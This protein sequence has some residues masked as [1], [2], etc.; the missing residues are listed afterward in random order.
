[1][2]NADAPVA[3]QTELKPNDGLTV[4]E[5]SVTIDAVQH[6]AVV[7]PGR[8]GPPVASAHPHSFGFRSDSQRRPKNDAMQGIA[9]RKVPGRLRVVGA[10]R[11]SLTL[12]G[13]RKTAASAGLASGIKK[14]GPHV[15]TLQGVTCWN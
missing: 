4:S 8:G 14:E 5:I 10:V 13:L 2:A 7:I 6:K 15:R 1:M 12:R 9:T 3:W 11:E